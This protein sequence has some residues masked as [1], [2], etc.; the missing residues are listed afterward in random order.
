MNFKELFVDKSK[1]LI[2]NTDLALIL[3]DLNEAIVLNQLN[4]WIEINKKAKKNF[5]DDKYWVYNSYSDWKAN[6]FPYWS[7]KTIQRTFTRLES[8]G[9]VISANYNKLAIDRTKW[10]TIDTKKLQKLVD[11]FNS[12]KD[13]KTERQDSMI[14][15]QDKMTYRE[16]QYDRPLP[17]NTPENT[18][19][20]CI[21]ENTSKS[22]SL[23]REQCNSFLPKD[24]K[25]KE[26]KP[27]SEYTQSD[28]EV[29]EERMISRAGKI[30]YEWTND[31]TLKENTEAFFKYFLDKHGECTG[32]Y[33]YPLTDKV[34][35]RV[36][37]NLTKET[38]IERDGY[39]DTYYAT[40]SDMD[41]N[42][43]YKMLVDEYFNTK[44]SAKCDYSLV[45][46]S[47]ENVLINIMNHACK[48]SW[49]ESKE[50]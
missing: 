25:A 16:E 49:C 12:D 24:K 39:T 33:H 34:L 48:G 46:F 41:D 32:E 22:N 21:S 9:I 7:E 42:T 31:E 5:I 18:N 47:S 23:N 1:T 20:D 50:W 17:E 37:D 2:I 29:A 19:R 8:K 4:Y 36:V 3:G 30:A 13:K 43:D 26:F 45:H 6:D 11:K 35:S 38:E 27:I 14:G 44:F 28:W 10:Y 40:I 15:Q